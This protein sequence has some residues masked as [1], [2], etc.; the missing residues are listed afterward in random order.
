[1]ATKKKKPRIDKH[2]LEGKLALKQIMQEGLA[3]I[4]NAM[5]KQIMGRARKSTPS[6]LINSIKNVD[7]TGVADYKDQIKTAL[8]IIASDAI[9]QVRREIPKAK[10]VKLSEGTKDNELQLS[11]FDD[12]PPDIQQRILAD[13]QTLI[14]T[15]LSDID[16][17]IFFQFTSSYDS[18]DSMD[19]LESDLENAAED[20]I[21]GSA[22]EAGADIMAAQIINTARDAFFMTEDVTDQLDALQFVNGDPVT[23]I[24]DKL[25][26]VIFSADDPLAGRFTPPFHWNCKTYI[27]PILKGNLD[28]PDDIEELS[29]YANLESEMQFS[30]GSDKL[31]LLLSQVRNH[32]H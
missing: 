1:M 11:E 9:K 15:Q 6:Q 21:G 14:G 28:S 3:N 10:K 2:I 12:L 25:D 7:H 13:A 24:C 27:I 32:K 18:T 19:L 16:K 23:N 17:V 5:I 31:I 4:A 26:G 30:E 8:S 22:I 20:Y 29:S